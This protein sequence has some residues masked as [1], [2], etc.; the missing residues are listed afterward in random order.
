LFAH[1]HFVLAS[2]CSGNKPRRGLVADDKFTVNIGASES[3]RTGCHSL[4]MKRHLGTFQRHA[5][6]RYAATY[7]YQ[8]WPLRRSLTTN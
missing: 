2:R 3:A 4:R 8:E 5:V 6:E 1:R 7:W